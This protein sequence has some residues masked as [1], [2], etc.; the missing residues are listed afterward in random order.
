MIK[1]KRKIGNLDYQTFIHTLIKEIELSCDIKTEKRFDNAIGYLGD[2]CRVIIYKLFSDYQVIKKRYGEIGFISNF[3]G[4]DLPNTYYIAL[5]DI[6]EH[7]K[8]QISSYLLNNGE[9]L[10]RNMFSV[11]E[12]TISEV[13][14]KI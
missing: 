6:K 5:G 10:K 3:Y 2:P 8:R 9:E 11:Q 4:G 1:D 12:G 14:L 7:I 13:I